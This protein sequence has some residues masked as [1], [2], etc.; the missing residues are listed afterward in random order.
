[1]SEILLFFT[2][3][4]RPLYRRDVLNV[5]TQPDTSRLTFGYKPGWVSAQASEKI[6]PGKEALIIF[7]EKV[8]DL[9]SHAWLH[10]D[11]F[12][13]T[14]ERG[15]SNDLLFFPLRAAIIRDVEIINGSYL[16]NLE[17]KSFSDPNKWMSRTAFIAFQYFIKTLAGNPAT[18]KESDRKYVLIGE[19]SGSAA[20][21]LLV[22]ERGKS[23]MLQLG[24]DCLPLINIS[25]KLD[26]FKDCFFLCGLEPSDLGRR[27]KLAG[28]NSSS[29]FPHFLFGGR[30]PDGQ[31]NIFKLK[32]GK[33][34][35]VRILVVTGSS[36]KKEEIPKLS[37]EEK[38]ST[39]SVLGPFVK[40]S[41]FGYQVEF[42]V[43]CK[44][45]LYDE[46]GGFSVKIDDENEDYKSSE[47]SGI[48]KVKRARWAIWLIV[49][50]IPFS[51]FLSTISPDVI[52]DFS[53]TSFN[54]EVCNSLVCLPMSPFS[55]SALAK[56]IGFGCSLYAAWLLTNRLTHK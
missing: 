23:F 3:S 5:C 39:V 47:L 40:Q 8:S 37:I 6:Q 55:V 38:L 41:P 54:Y 33:N 24:S 17:L 21:P 27:E 51:V 7:S 56:A 53:N 11:D 43:R 16:I 25:K 10:H 22:N 48:I 44:H 14:S 45:S 36:T 49:G 32:V 31:R 2:T 9:N 52:R 1:M 19:Y 13:L 30:E 20:T 29:F 18:E 26:V 46:W 34:Y 12:Y 15:V 28:D 50:L 35:R 42:L 4:F